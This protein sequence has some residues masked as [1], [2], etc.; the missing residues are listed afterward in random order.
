MSC[1]FLVHKLLKRT[2]EALSLHTRARARS[3]LEI[4]GNQG[5]SLMRQHGGLI[6]EQKQ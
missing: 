1:F 3:H 5:Y 6:A 4:G 2:F